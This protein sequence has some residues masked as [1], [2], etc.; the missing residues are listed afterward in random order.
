MLSA[1]KEADV[2]VNTSVSE[3]MS[4]A[5]LEAMGIGTPVMAR[6]IPAN[7]ALLHKDKVGILFSTPKDFHEKLHHLIINDQDN[8]VDDLIQRAKNFVNEYSMEKE[9]L[10]YFC[11]MY[12]PTNSH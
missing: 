4:G 5:I 8:Y 2:V 7:N 10:G 11:R 9:G 6:N 3:G 12:L 1:M